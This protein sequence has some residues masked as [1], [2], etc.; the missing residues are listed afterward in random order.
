LDGSSEVA[1]LK[2]CLKYQSGIILGSGNVKGQQ[3]DFVG[4]RINWLAQW[5]VLLVINYLIEQ[6]VHENNDL[7]ILFDGL[8]E[9][10]RFGL[11]HWVAFF[12]LRL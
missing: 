11:E 7:N 5:R 4:L 8:F 9:Y 1:S 3:I 2:P 6:S 12:I 10:V